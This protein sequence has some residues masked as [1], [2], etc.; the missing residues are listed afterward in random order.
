VES[1]NLKKMSPGSIH[2]G[3]GTSPEKARSV[4]FLN[5]DYSLCQGCGGCAEAY[6][7]FFEM[8][9]DKAWVINADKFKAEEHK[10][11]LL[12]CPYYAISIEQG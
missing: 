5:I 6:P 7:M 3:K 1:K 11:I 9:D 4:M 10:D 8:R 12:V 2:E